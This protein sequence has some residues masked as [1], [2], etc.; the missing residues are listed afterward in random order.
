MLVALSFLYALHS[1]PYPLLHPL[2]VAVGAGRLLR[3][4]R[5]LGDG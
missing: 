5:L 1:I 4:V 3:G 2:L